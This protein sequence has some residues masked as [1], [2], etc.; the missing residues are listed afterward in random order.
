MVF[1]SI[2]AT[3][4]DFKK[5]YRKAWP[6]NSVSELIVSNKFGEVR[7]NESVGDSVTILATITI[8]NRSSSKAQELS[9]KIN[10]SLDKNGNTVSG[11]TTI[12]LNFTSNQ[13]FS[14]DYL[15]N[16]PKTVN[17]NIT[18][19][20]GNL[21]MKDL[22][23]HAYIDIAYG[24]ITAGNLKSPA[25]KN[26]NI[27]LSYG[28]ADIES[29]TSCKME[30]NYSKLYLNNSEQIELDSKYSTFNIHNIKDLNLIS[31]YDD[32]NIDE[33][34]NLKSESKY[35]HYKIGNLVKNFD[36][37]NGYGSVLIKKVTA[38]FESI[39]IDSSYGSIS[40]LMP[41]LNY[42]LN[43]SCS[44]CDVK[45]PIEKFKGNRIK[46]NTSISV[47]GNVGVGG[48]KVLIKSRY[49]NIKLMN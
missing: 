20:Y 10:I 31:K 12:D 34:Y 25:S 40:I 28:R 43:A 17:I 42:N 2:G 48:G 32:F 37:T 19:K 44:Y 33:I 8:E 11:I 22:E 36:L 46:E 6:K 26:S 45:Y 18:N 29:I 14:I 3:A 49:G 38:G 47:D 35:T 23:A 1:I 30:L 15:I 39:K 27:I 7:I 5:Q 41:E 16:V 4:Q 9:R 24:S 21:V 13:K